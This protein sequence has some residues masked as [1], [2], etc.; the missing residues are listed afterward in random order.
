M[1]QIHRIVENSWD[2]GTD[3][4]KFNEWMREHPTFKV[5]CMNVV[6]HREHCEFY[7]V[8]DIP[9]EEGKTNE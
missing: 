4:R 3:I 9:D 8:I 1:Q 2:K 5:V 7:A 6:P